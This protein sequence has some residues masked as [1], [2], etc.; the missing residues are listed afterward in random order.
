[1]DVFRFTTTLPKEYKYTVGEEVKKE[2]LAML[3]DIY[4]ANRSFDGRKDRIVFSLEH[5]ETVRI[6]LRILRDL[7]HIDLKKF[8]ALSEQLENVSRQLTGWRKKS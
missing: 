5:L 4:R 7:G 3:L 8:V 6:L 1:M 2:T